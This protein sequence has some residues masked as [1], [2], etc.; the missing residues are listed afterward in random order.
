MEKKTKKIVG[1]TIAIVMAFVLVATPL[2]AMGEPTETT[3]S[4]TIGTDNPTDTTQEDLIAQQQAEAER[5]A[6]EKRAAELEKLKKAKKKHLKKIRKGYKSWKSYMTDNQKKSYKVKIKKIK[7]AKKISTIVVKHKKIKK[8]FKKA[9]AYKKEHSYR[10]KVGVSCYG[11]YE[12]ECRT[13]TGRTITNGT[14]YVAVPMSRIVSYSSWKKKSQEGKRHYFYYHEKVYLKNGSRTCTAYVEDCGGFGYM[15]SYGYYRLFD[16]TP[17]VFHKLG[18]SG[19][20][21]V[22]WHY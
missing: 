12:G 14:Y 10:N 9:K 22:T 1:T 16:L 15:K 8:I 19:I 7:K 4:E 13:A 6:A 2:S 17:A 11:P 5:I 21:T 3:G 18:I 20:G